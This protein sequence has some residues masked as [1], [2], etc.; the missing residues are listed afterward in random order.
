MRLLI[1]SCLCSSY[2]SLAYC[3][4]VFFFFNATATTEIYTLSLHDALPICSDEE[5]RR[6]PGAKDQGRAGAAPA[7]GAARAAR[8]AADDAQ[9]PPVRRRADGG[10]PQAA[11][12]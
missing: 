11:A 10:G 7:P 8:H 12:P 4:G 1:R 5:R 2:P 3:P 9:E 6:A